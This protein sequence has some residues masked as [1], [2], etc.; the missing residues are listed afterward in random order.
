M[1]Q[2]ELDTIQAAQEALA[3]YADTHLPKP[4]A[5]N[6]WWYQ[7]PPLAQGLELEILNARWESTIP[8]TCERNDELFKLWELTH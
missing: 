5:P 6:R 1:T 2:A 4:F 7:S 8:E 3:F